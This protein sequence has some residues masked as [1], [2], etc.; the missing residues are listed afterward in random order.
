MSVSDLNKIKKK[1]SDISKKNYHLE[2]RND[3]VHMFGHLCDFKFYPDTFET[4]AVDIQSTSIRY[5]QVFSYT[6][7][8]TIYKV[9]YKYFFFPKNRTRLFYSNNGQIFIDN[10]D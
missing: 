5:K 4:L 9:E 10:I 2:I 7:S 1:L 6:D 8:I 3:N